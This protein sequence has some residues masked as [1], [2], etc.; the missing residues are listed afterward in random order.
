MYDR[1]ETREEWE[2]DLIDVQHSVTPAEGIR[3]VQILT[4]KLT[5]SPAPIPDF[6]HLVML[7]LGGTFLGVAFVVFSSDIQH[8]AAFGVPALATG[9]CLAAAA[10]WRRRKR[11]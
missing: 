10:F 7:V 9:C 1:E 6:A 4:K 2:R 5:T 11:G 3:S 8:R